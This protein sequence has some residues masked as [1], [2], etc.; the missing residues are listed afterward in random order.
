M[1]NTALKARG[2]KGRPCFK[3]ATTPRGEEEPALLEAARS[4][5]AADRSLEAK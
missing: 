3:S 2:T 4:T 5:I 1:E